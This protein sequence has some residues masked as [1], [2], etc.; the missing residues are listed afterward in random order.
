MQTGEPYQTKLNPAPAD[1]ACRHPKKKVGILAF[2]SLIGDPG[3]E[4]APKIVMRIKTPTPFGVE[5][6]RYSIATRGGAPTLVPHDAGAPVSGEIL[7]LDDT[8]TID[9]ARNMLWRRERRREGT[10]ETYLDGTSPNSVLVR[11]WADSPC[12]S[13]VLYTD[14]P[15]DGKTAKPAANELATHA[16]ESVKK[17]DTA[18]DGITYLLDAMA[19]GIKTPLTDSYYKEILLQTKSRSLEE[20]RK[21]AGEVERA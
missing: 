7:V 9:E 2:G 17:A 12:V 11:Q 20:A 3:S 8:V 10:G 14:F 16:I 1:I 21:K 18:K 19:A 13:T 4:I 6:G 15:P 5:Y